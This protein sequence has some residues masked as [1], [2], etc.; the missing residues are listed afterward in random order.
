M[1]YI[2]NIDVFGIGWGSKSKFWDNQIRSF[3]S[4]QNQHLIGFLMLVLVKAQ[5]HRSFTSKTSILWGAQ[6]VPQSFH[7]VQTLS[8]LSLGQP[9][10]SMGGFASAINLPL[11]KNFLV[12]FSLELW[13]LTSQ[14]FLHH[15][16]WMEVSQNSFPR[17][18]SYH[19][20]S[21]WA[22]L[23]LKPMV[24]GIPPLAQNHPNIVRQVTR[25]TL[26]WDARS[27][28]REI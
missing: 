6:L 20:P 16:S 9:H 2:I 26:S 15:R 5:Y 18:W 10:L 21:H 27:T 23:V 1:L 12:P 28:A 17:S 13:G 7:A 19:H 22:I 25:S 4:V 3:T 8:D 11:P 14:T 24:L